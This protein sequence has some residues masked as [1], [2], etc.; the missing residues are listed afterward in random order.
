VSSRCS[1]RGIGFRD[2]LAIGTLLKQAQGALPR[3]FHNAIRTL[4]GSKISQCEAVVRITSRPSGS[5][6]SPSV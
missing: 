5:T 3:V 4:A 2:Q 6:A 1:N